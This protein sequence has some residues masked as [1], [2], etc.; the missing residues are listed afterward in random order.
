MTSEGPPPNEAWDAVP[1]QEIDTG[2]E[3]RSLTRSV[4]PGATAPETILDLARPSSTSGGEEST[5]G[6]PM[7]TRAGSPLETIPEDVPTEDTT[8]QASLRRPVDKRARV[9]EI[10]E[11]MEVEE[12][13][14]WGAPDRV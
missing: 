8:E 6:G 13:P 4:I 14:P 9:G 7:S 5:P 11:E 12:P 3:P 1:R 10:E 2:P